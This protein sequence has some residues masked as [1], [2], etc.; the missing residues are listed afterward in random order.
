YEQA[1]THCAALGIA[2]EE[3]AS[4]TSLMRLLEMEHHFTDAPRHKQDIREFRAVL[5]ATWMRGV[6]PGASSTPVADAPPWSVT[7]VRNILEPILRSRQLQNVIWRL[8]GMQYEIGD[9]RGRLSVLE[10]EETRHVA[11]TRKAL[12]T[13]ILSVVEHA[14]GR[15]DVKAIYHRELAIRKTISDITASAKPGEDTFENPFAP[16]QL[17]VEATK[18]SPDD[19]KKIAELK[20]ELKAAAEQRAA[21]TAKAVGRLIAERRT[22]NRNEPPPLPLTDMETLAATVFDRVIRPA[23]DAP[24]L[25]TPDAR[26]TMAGEL[27][28]EWLGSRRGKRSP[29]RQSLAR[30]ANLYLEALETIGI[31]LRNVSEDS[32][33]LDADRLRSLQGE[34]NT[35]GYYLNRGSLA[36]NISSCDE[37][38][39]LLARLLEAAR[40]ALPSFIREEQVARTRL[41]GLYLAA[42]QQ[43]ASSPGDT[44]RD[45]VAEWIEGDL[46]MIERNP[47]APLVPRLR[48][49]ALQES[50]SAANAQPPAGLA[51]FTAATGNLT[52]AIA[53]ERDATSLLAAQWE[54]AGLL[55][56]D[57]V[58]PA[59]KALAAAVLEYESALAHQATAPDGPTAVE[60]RLIGLSLTD[61][62]PPAEPLAFVRRGLSGLS[63]VDAEA[64]LLE[65][66]EGCLPLGKPLEVAAAARDRMASAAHAVMDLESALNRG[67]TDMAATIG[68]TLD[69]LGRAVDGYEHLA[70]LAAIDISYVA[71]L[72]ADVERE[73][74]LFLRVREAVGRYRGRAGMAVRMLEKRAGRELD[75]G[76]LSSLSGDLTIIKA[77]VQALHNSLKTAIDEY[78]EP[79]VAKKYPILE[80]F[81]ETRAWLRTAY[82]LADASKSAEVAS[83]FIKT[84]AAARLEFLDSRST[85]LDAAVST[86]RSAEVKLDAG[87]IDT[88]AFRK[89]VLIA[90]QGFGD[91]L[92]ALEATGEGPMEKRFSG[93]IDA[94]MGR[95]NKLAQD[96]RG[97]QATQQR[98][99]LFELA[100]ILKES[101]RLRRGVRSEIDVAAGP[102]L[103]YAGGPDRI[104]LQETRMDAEISRQRLLGQIRH[105]RRRFTLG[106]L[107]ALEPSPDAGLAAQVLPWGLFCHRVARSPLSGVVT[108][109]RS[110]AG[111]DS[112]RDPL[113]KW[114]LE[115]LEEASRETRSED[116][117]RNYPGITR[118][119][120][121]SLKDFMRY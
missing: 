51:V 53:V 120:I 47:F 39:R 34:L 103:E 12:N 67:D 60:R 93:D 101:E 9:I 59:E 115:Q 43:M 84:F 32:E 113:V 40:P 16:V 25:T 91:F 114:L 63:L 117:L 80:T 20:A 105:G 44:H 76:Q 41:H 54:L 21:L 111:G 71:P 95:L 121:Q 74:L 38:A 98:R 23:L 81:I 85:L 33:D 10:A 50:L 61:A 55:E 14:F 73:E 36:K 66:A 112:R 8:F 99:R 88:T 37:V 107:V 49:L 17:D 28:E 68:R 83:G 56:S 45:L 82:E 58:S 30:R 109:P 29:A 26:R 116:S 48:D 97:N 42:W 24:A 87:S 4:V 78:A 90:R 2:L 119:L 6:I 69:A 3:E 79:N 96:T 108:P 118:E 13:F 46:L 27:A 11:A 1:F 94:L 5:F 22:A 18:L 65:A 86:L 77:G 19:E 64:K 92:S 15:N 35:A 52:D 89:Q 62:V 31:D 110:E 104:W 57:R 70:R 72:G 106:V 75:A 7:L 102:R 100:E